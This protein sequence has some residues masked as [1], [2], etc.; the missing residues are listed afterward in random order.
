MAPSDVEGG[1]EERER[2]CELQVV[3]TCSSVFEQES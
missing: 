3:Y 1:G 2:V